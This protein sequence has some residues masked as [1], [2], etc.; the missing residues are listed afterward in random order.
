M[1]AKYLPKT[2]EEL[3]QEFERIFNNM[4]NYKNKY[5]SI[6]FAHSEPDFLQFYMD[7]KELITQI[8]KRVER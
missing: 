8:T 3:E 6:A 5:K 1:E 7:F 4:I 2:R